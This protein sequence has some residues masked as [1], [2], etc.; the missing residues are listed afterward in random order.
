MSTP[1]AI[2]AINIHDFASFEKEEALGSNFINTFRRRD[3][4]SGS[5]KRP[6][7]KNYVKDVMRAESFLKA[8]K[9]YSHRSDS[10]TDD[11]E[12]DENGA[13]SPQGARRHSHRR[14][15][16]NKGRGG[17]QLVHQESAAEESATAAASETAA[18]TSEDD[19]VK[20]QQDEVCNGAVDDAAEGSSRLTGQNDDSN[21]VDSFSPSTSSDS[22]KAVD[23]TE[24]KLDETTSKSIQPEDTS[25]G[26][27]DT[28][29]TTPTTTNNN[30]DLSK[31]GDEVETAVIIK[32]TAAVECASAPPP[33]VQSDQQESEKPSIVKSSPES[34]DVARLPSSLPSTAVNDKCTAPLAPLASGDP[35]IT[36]S[37]LTLVD[38][39][40][41]KPA[42]E[43]ES[44]P[45]AAT[46]SSTA[47]HSSSG[48]NVNNNAT[49]VTETATPVVADDEVPMKKKPAASANQPS[50]KKGETTKDC[51]SLQ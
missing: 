51:C 3:T 32:A 2:Q 13:Q 26:L 1:E 35:D 10:E 43:K 23:V 49:A 36:Q 29:A 27:V 14:R 6:S 28:E 4:A 46:S 25:S 48:D 38:S 18:V 47:P 24:V 22:S 31:K 8:L 42:A 40:A 33:I 12:T 45:A 37:N 39:E 16:S 50:S 19:S 21:P 20:K 44:K 15:R 34:L 17:K 7:F 11:T 41:S 9:H 30:E 5:K